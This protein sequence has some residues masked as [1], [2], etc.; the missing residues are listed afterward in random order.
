[1][2]VVKLFIFEI[3]K[4]ILSKILG[5]FGVS[6]SVLAFAAALFGAASSWQSPDL[7]GVTP[8]DTGGGVG[9]WTG[10]EG[11]TGTPPSPKSNW[12][13]FSSFSTHNQSPQ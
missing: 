9:E 10:K 11:R 13:D 5:L 8:M 2:C 6:S 12:A 4:M 3:A 7:S 1:M